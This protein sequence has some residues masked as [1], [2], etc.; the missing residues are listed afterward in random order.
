MI[1]LVMRPTKE[2]VVNYEGLYSVDMNGVPLGLKVRAKNAKA[3]EAKIMFCFN[4]E[5]NGKTLD[6]NPDD[7]KEKSNAQT[8]E[9]PASGL[10]DGVPG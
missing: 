8:K 1:C 5:L 6:F 2:P 4:R 3:A 9:T 7:Y 10:R